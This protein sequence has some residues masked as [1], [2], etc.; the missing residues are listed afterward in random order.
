MKK[1][2]LFATLTSSISFSAMA[3]TNSDRGSEFKS[4]KIVQSAN[5]FSTNKSEKVMSNTY[6]ECGW[7]TVSVSCGETF[8]AHTYS[9]GF[10]DEFEARQRLAETY[11]D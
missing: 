11:C 8:Y 5:A 7:V 9:C 3:T 2:L 1:A 4:I 10:V 6:D